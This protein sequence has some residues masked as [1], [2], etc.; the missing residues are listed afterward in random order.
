MVIRGKAIFTAQTALISASG[1]Y[2]TVM[3]QSIAQQKHT[4]RLRKAIPQ[5]QGNEKAFGIIKLAMAERLLALR[6]WIVLDFRQYLAAYAWNCLDARRPIVLDPMKDIASFLNDAATLQAASAQ[7]YANVRAQTR[8]FYL[9]SGQVKKALNGNAA[10]NGNDSVV[11]EKVG[12]SVFLQSE[13][14]LESLRNYRTASFALD[15]ENPIFQNY[16]RLRVRKARIFLQHSGANENNIVSLRV[17]LGAA[18]K[19]L[20]L[21][22]IK[23]PTT[24]P[25]S[26][27]APRVLHFVTTESTFGFEYMGKD[28]EVLMDGAFCGYYE[29]SSL[30]LSPFRAWTVA[31]DSETNLESVT[32]LTLE[33]TCEVTYL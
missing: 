3:Q 4:D 21:E 28:K 9:S 30:L 12:N 22:K 6:S 25:G 2:L 10:S 29:S 15:C 23:T 18:M 26:V 16:G 13:D 7:V 33:L 8:V 14:L 27:T 11:N 24:G 5:I 20:S 31:V 1:A 32:G 19:D 17:T